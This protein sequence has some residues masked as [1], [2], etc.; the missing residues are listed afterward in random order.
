MYLN[1][2]TIIGFS[3]SEADTHQT[4]N[5]ALTATVSVATKGSWKDASGE[6]QSRTEWHGVVCFGKLAECRRTL[7]KGSHLIGA[8]SSAHSRVS[9][10]Q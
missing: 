9:A 5:G 2:L 6:W 4:S 7:A 10:G 3:G 1:H 8:G